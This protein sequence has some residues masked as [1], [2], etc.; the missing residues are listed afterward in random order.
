MIILGI[1]YAVP[2][3][4]FAGIMDLLPIVGSIIGAVPAIVI[5]FSLSPVKG[6]TLLVVHLIYQQLENSVISPMVYRKTMSISSV[7]SFL[8]VII[9]ASL[10]GVV[11]AF[12]ALPVAAS[13]PVLIKYREKLREGE[14]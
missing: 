1:P 12:I 2:L 7:L 13:I 4:I 6:V 5:A 8:S 10:F 3:G 14:R 11:G 9:G